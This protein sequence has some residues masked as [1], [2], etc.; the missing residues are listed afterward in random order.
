MRSRIRWS[1]PSLAALVVC[2]PAGACSAG[3]VGASPPSAKESISALT[4]FPVDL[5]GE[6]SR[7]VAEVLGLLLEKKGLSSIEIADST[8]APP[9]GA[10]SEEVGKAFGAF[11]AA[12]PVRTKHALFARI[13]GERPASGPPRI[14]GLFGVVVGA[15]GA[16]AWQDARTPADAE[17]KRLRSV[18]PMTLCVLLTDHL[19]PSLALGDPPGEDGAM[20]QL[21]AAKSHMPSAAEREAMSA[22]LAVLKSKGAAARVLVCPIRTGTSADRAAA[23][24]LAKRLAGDGLCAASVATGDWPISVEPSR[25]EQRMLWDMAHAV[26]ARTRD[27]APDADY[28]LFIDC[29]ISSRGTVGAVHFAVCDR[30]GE[31]VLVDFQNDHHDDFRAVAPHDAAKAGELVARRWAVRCR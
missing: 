10:A 5:G 2:C 24:A 11:V 29:L 13:E 28:V 4:I 17:W 31:L 1:I 6:P 27:A 14:T 3:S 26:Q 25:N 15:D 12:H 23:E 16:V 9:E 8:F 19:A 20:A 21:W 7:D 30:A 22:R 18:E